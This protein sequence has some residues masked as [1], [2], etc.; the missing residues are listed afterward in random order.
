MN[1]EPKPNP[2]FFETIDLTGTINKDQ[3]FEVIFGIFGQ[4]TIYLE[5]LINAL[6]KAGENGFTYARGKATILRI[7]QVFE[8][9]PDKLLYDPQH[10]IIPAVINK[11]FNVYYNEPVECVELEFLSPTRLFFYGE[12]VHIEKFNIRRFFEIL[13][14]RVQTIY[15]Y[16][17][18]KD[19][20]ELYP[21]DHIYEIIKTIKV[22]DQQIE[23]FN[24]TRYSNRQE[25]HI[26][27]NGFVGKV[28]LMGKGLNALMPYLIVGEQIH[29]GRATVMGLGKYKLNCINLNN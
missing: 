2:Y 28:I 6:A 25:K 21:I 23:H 7:Y 5:Y 15:Y 20:R 8:N 13:I 3:T 4:K 12:P 16:H 19:F 11:K 9:Q 24:F 27:L 18:R 14:T 17:E 10:I 29:L 26:E 1:I 22:Y